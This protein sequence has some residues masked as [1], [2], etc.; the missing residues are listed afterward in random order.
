MHGI[1]NKP[2]YSQVETKR[3]LAKHGITS[4]T[5][6]PFFPV[7]TLQI[8]RGAIYAQRS[9]F[10]DQYVDEVYKHMWSVPRK[11]DDPDVIV[12]ALTESGFDI[13]GFQ[14]GIQNPDVKKA[15]IDNTNRSVDMG[16]FGSPTF[17]V[18]GEIYF[19]KDKM[20]EVEEAILKK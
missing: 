16:C 11:M 15:L 17:F 4:Y 5:S 10:F 12:E 3:F 18:D 7:N 19:G 20:V 2:E 14:A 1:K 6:N 13:P 8:M 9:G